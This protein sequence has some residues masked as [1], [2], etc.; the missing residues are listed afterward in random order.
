MKAIIIFWIQNSS[1]K[2]HGSVPVTHCFGFMNCSTLW[3]L[4]VF[5]IK[6][7]FHFKNPIVCCMLLGNYLML[8]LCSASTI[9]IHMYIS[10]NIW[11]RFLVFLLSIPYK[12]KYIYSDILIG[13]YCGITC[14]T[15]F[16]NH[17]Y[18]N[19]HSHTSTHTHAIMYFVQIK[20]D[21]RRQKPP[22]ISTLM[23]FPSQFQIAL[24]C[25]AC[26]YI[27]KKH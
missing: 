27:F 15:W 13:L 17:Y 16:F 20:M 14:A 5:Y 24:S 26:N 6:S 25:L 2:K 18:N 22:T 8:F 11:A 7:Y 1:F 9:H 19:V 21:Y 3:Q 12:I 10:W 4:D 23:E